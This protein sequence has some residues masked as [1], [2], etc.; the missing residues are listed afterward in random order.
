MKK[1]LLLIMSMAC[2]SFA[3]AQNDTLL[4]ENFNSGSLPAG[5]MNIDEDGLLQDTTSG[6]L[7]QGWFFSEFIVDSGDSLEIVAQS[8]SWLQD[9]LPG[10]KDWLITPAINI[11]DTT[12]MLMWES[13]PAQVGIYQDG[14]KVVVSTTTTALTSFT[15]TLAVYAQNINNVATDFST[16]TVHTASTPNPDM[17]DGFDFGLLAQWQLSLSAYAGQTI[18]I[19]FL[20][21]SDDDWILAIDDVMVKKG[22]IT[23]IEENTVVYNL[24]VFPN[25]TSD[26]IRVEFNSTVTD[27]LQITILSI[28]GKVVYNKMYGTTNQLQQDISVSE[29]PAGNYFVYLRNGNHINIEKFAVVK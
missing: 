15:D 17:T 29:L 21:D 11:T 20:H 25:P 28:D 5:W 3:N 9:F 14:Y 2:F 22:A 7:V 26:V 19:A 18:Y 16:G 6:V 4:Y 23:S 13:A 24:S 1:Q 8:S 27:N 12:A 10:N